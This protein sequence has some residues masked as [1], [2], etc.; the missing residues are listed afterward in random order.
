MPSVLV[1]C[2]D[3]KRRLPSV[4]PGDREGAGR[5]P[6]GLIRA[7]RRRIGFINGQ[8]GLDN[9]RDRLRGYRQALASND[10]PF[11]PALVQSGN[12][13]PD[14]GHG[15]RARCW[16]WPSRPTPSSAPTTSWRWAAT[17]PSRRRAGASPRTWR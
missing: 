11:D 3:A 7:G 1:N 13:E 17:T 5:R 12:W 10:L 6:N 2:Y 4:L 14:G 16:P 9:S 8:D 15:G